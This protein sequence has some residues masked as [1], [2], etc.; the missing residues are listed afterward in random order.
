MLAPLPRHANRDPVVAAWGM[1]LDSTAMLI[2]LVAQGDAPDVVLTA[3]T[4][5]ERDE[6]YAFLPI[7][8]RWMDDHGLEHH[9]VRYAPKR[10][11]HWPPYASILENVLT[12]ATLPSISM[13]R[14]SCSLKWKVEPQDRWVRAWEPAKAAWAAGRTVTKLIGYD[15][16]AADTRRSQHAATIE[17][18]LY[19][20]RY[21]LRE[22]G[23]DRARCVARI[24][25]EGLPVP[26]K[27]ACFI[28]GASRPEEVMTLPAW[29]LRLIVLVEA[30][31]KPRLRTVEGLW[32]KSTRTRPGMMTDFIRAKNLLDPREIDDI[33][34]H[35]PQDL[36]AFQ[37]VAALI[38]VEERPHMSEWLDRFN[39]GAERLAA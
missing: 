8:Q 39:A 6:T 13:G 21:P 9:V 11:K 34:A 32:R 24:R 38:P 29:C 23:W 12:N 37:E 5:A 33:I 30:R 17:N 14:G 16:G 19:T 35:A 36:L 10:F 22:W 28:C 3:D 18:P 31:A 15:A 2:E 25:E 1:G 27:S 26:I 7:F 20:F 4:G